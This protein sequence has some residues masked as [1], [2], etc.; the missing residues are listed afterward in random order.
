M[1]RYGLALI[2]IVLLGCGSESQRPPPDPANT[3]GVHVERYGVTQ[4]GHA[5]EEFTLTNRRG[6][7]ARLISYGGV[8]TELW[9]PDRDGRMDDVVLGFDNL[10]QFEAENHYFGTITGR[11]ANRIAQGQF[12][13]DGQTY[14]LAIND[15]PNHLHGGVK[16]FDR[17]VWEGT[18]VPSPA[19]PAVRFNHLSPDGDEGYPGNLA[20]SVT[21][22]LTHDNALTI[23]YEAKTDQATPVN[24]TNHAYFNLAGHA[25]GPVYEQ[26]LLLRAAT[27]TEFDSVQ[28]PTGRLL[29][30]AGTP[31][32]FTVATPIGS[33]IDQVGTG[34]DQNFVIDAADGS[35]LPAAEAYDPSSGRL[36]EVLTTQ[37]GVQLYT[38]NHF[39]QVVGKG[40]ALYVQHQGFCLET[41]NFPDAINHDH[42]PTP[43][44]RPGATYRHTTVHRFSTR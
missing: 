10:A 18:P 20:V 33:R 13:L 29:P 36:M 7:V 17:V 31:L 23:E 16:A 15:A 14:Q 39:E 35:L 8:L 3:A 12:S 42:F 37:P 41:Q 40:G 32:D 28:I 34:Y 38:G 6:A 25:A 22:Q 1:R 43:V 2:T 4:D 21:Y 30:V 24:L 44:L 19:G 27:Y 11:V 26:T 9:V 5:V